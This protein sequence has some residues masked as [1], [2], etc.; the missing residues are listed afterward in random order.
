VLAVEAVIGEPV[1]TRL[2]PVAR[3]NTGKFLAFEASH[4]DIA[5]TSGNKIKAFSP[6]SLRIETGNFTE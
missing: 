1:S 5:L 2:F 6:N 3:E 4:G